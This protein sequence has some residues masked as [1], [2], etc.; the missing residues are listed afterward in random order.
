[1]TLRFDEPWWLLVGA[2]AIPA[3]WIALRWLRGMSRW[4][5]WSVALFRASLLIVAGAALA[6]ASMVQRAERVATIAL[7]DVSESVRRDAAGP[8]LDLAR[9]W[10]DALAQEMA[11]DD[12]LGVVAFAD[13]A[14]AAAAPV[15]GGPDAAD[16]TLDLDLGS[17]TNIARAIELAAAMAPP[18]ARAR[19]VII[20]DGV[21][22]TGDA[23]E[24]ATTLS[25]L[26]VDVVPIE[27]RVP[28]DAI[29]EFVDA[30]PQAAA[31]SRVLVRVGVRASDVM[32]GEI[33]L[34][35]GDRWIDVNGTG[36]G[37]G[38]AVSLRPGLNVELFDLQLDDRAVH[39]IEAVF[40]P[41]EESAD[42]VALN[43]RA[44]AVTITPGRGRALLIDG[45][46]GDSAQRTPLEG[47]LEEAGFEL[48]VIP[49]GETP[50][51]LLELQAYDLIVMQNVAAD[52]TPRASHP[53]L[54]DFVQQLGGGMVVVGGPDAL[55]A[56][57]WNGTALEPV[58]PVKLDLPEE[59]IVPSAAIAMVLDS[60]GSMARRVLGGARSQ[61]QI[62][63]EAAALAVQT[64]DRTDLVAVYG[65]ADQPYTVIPL[66]PNAD[67]AR[68]AQRIRSIAPGGGTNLYPAL[69]E[70]GEEMLA[71]EADVKHVIVLSDGQS[72]GDPMDGVRTAERL[73]D[74]GVTVTAIAVGDGA[75]TFT[76][77]QIAQAG[78]GQFYRVVDPNV[79]PR[80]FVREIRVVRKPLVREEPFEPVLL[81][82]GSPATSG[83]GDPPVLRGLVLTQP[84]P[85]PEITLAMVTPTGEPVLAH[86]NTGLGRAAVFT[87]DASRWASAWLDWPGFRAMWTQLS[88]Y[89][90]RPP[91]SRDAELT[92]TLEGDELVLR[93]DAADES[94]DP[95]NLLN[96]PAIVYTPGGESLRLRLSQVGPGVYEARA[97]ATESGSYVVAAT[98]RQG[99]RALAPALVGVSRS[100][101]LELRSLES[102]AARLRELAEATGGRVHDVM[103]P[104]Q[105][106]AI[107]DRT[108]LEP[109]EAAQPLWPILLLWALGVYVLDIATRRV[110][111]DRIL[112][113]EMA[114]ARRLAGE[115]R[116]TRT[117]AGA[118]KQSRAQRA[119][120]EP[121][122]APASEKQDVRK[123]RQAER[124]AVE[125]AIR[126][127]EAPKD[128][129]ARPSG[130][131]EEPAEDARS[132][133][134]A[135]KRRAS[136]R[137]RE[138]E[139]DT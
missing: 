25:P 120:S 75:D 89:A 90:S 41:A 111:W 65:F 36:E 5:A 129:R 67:P 97:P 110:A 6:G 55:G 38:R 37:L 61:Q 40:Q 58:L 51:D 43:N 3:F 48:T 2:L 71:A 112:S 59:L 32:E 88:R 34:R 105:A 63:N 66:S 13:R 56:G 10:I 91:M 20:S 128:V 92:A 60:S 73:R 93:L 87:S 17:G 81:D 130:E 138:D 30:P 121:D 70:A 82:A 23:I 47:V 16:L 7:V 28:S 132:G 4:R 96:V 123:Q 95:L 49:P 9:R 127:A 119:L 115:K 125:R 50:A 99:D 8:A 136:R 74:A 116:E 22:T 64:L 114:T 53:V 109:V 133:L 68:N 113:G 69:R 103:D 94:G 126:E 131:V 24:T 83:L 52:E 85:E 78:G 107:W 35:R 101:G 62:A 26:R 80:V 100:A 134:L 11:P 42:A 76:L 57:G 45:V 14:V 108:D 98:P 44:G 1:M 39:R 106:D 19:L 84:R 18:D 27:Y 137:F 54:A 104:T 135:A 31:E 29:V 46:A 117:I 15:R 79:L 102:N 118:W 77:Q 124:R 12:S 21:E 139:S 72:T 122:E 86:W 33:L